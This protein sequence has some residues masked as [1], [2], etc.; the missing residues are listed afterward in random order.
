M[1]SIY[2]IYV[3][4]GSSFSQSLNLSGN[5]SGQTISMTVVDGIGTKT[6]GYTT[7]TDASLGEFDIAM[8][9]IQTSA[10]S[11]GIGKYDIE[12]NDGVNG[13]RILQGRVY[14]DG[15]VK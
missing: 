14:I 12:T 7:W 5:Y 11:S 10:M 9:S 8:T 13:H 3:E 1:A 6:T 15:E 2:D 4:Q